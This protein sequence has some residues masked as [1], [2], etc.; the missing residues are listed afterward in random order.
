MRKVVFLFCIGIFG[1]EGNSEGLKVDPNGTDADSDSDADTDIDT[2]SDTDVD[3]DTDSD[4]DSDS[5][6]DSDTDSDSDSDSDSDTDSDSDAEYECIDDDSDWWCAPFDCNDDDADVNPGH[7]EIPDNGV[8]DDCDGQTDETLE[9]LDNDGDGLS[10]ELELEL[11]LDPDNEDSDGDGVSDLVELVA[12]TDPLDPDSNPEAEGNFYFLVPYNED[13]DPTE[14]TLTFATDINMADLFFLVDTTGSMSGEI[15]NLTNSLSDYII[16]EVQAIISDVWFGVGRYDDYPVNPY[17]DALSNDVV[18]ELNQQMTSNTTL[19]QNAVSS[20]ST[21]W[22]YDEPESTVPALYATATGEGFGSYLDPQ[23][24]CGPDTIGYPCFRDGAIPIIMLITDA[25]FHN[26]PSNYSPYSSIF[27]VPPTYDETVD[28][29]N[30]IYAKVL[31]IY[32]TGGEP[33]AYDHCVAISTDTGAVDA[34]DNPLVYSIDG[35]G[36]GLDEEVVNAVETLAFNVPIDILAEERDDE[37]DSVDATI[38][39]DYITPYNVDTSECT[40]GFVLDDVDTDPYDDVFLDVLPGT[41]V[42]FDIIPAMNTTVPATSEPQVFKAFIDVIGDYVTTLDTREVFFL[43][44]PSE[45]LVD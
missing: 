20:L 42:C 29:L 37:T 7:E 14:D 17:G 6:T 28:A 31:S 21:H 22:G 34:F 12:G 43:V 18:F 15:S 11:G 23:T 35:M 39:I 24:D 41:P 2:D 26:G 19:A 25:T 13:P 33:M 27:P 32:S 44:P 1:C 10:N 5:D 30:G 38:F 9:V 16:P 45:P 8:D 3:S 4:S 36:N 40:G